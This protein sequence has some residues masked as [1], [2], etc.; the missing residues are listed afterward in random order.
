M[1]GAHNL[2]FTHWGLNYVE[3]DMGWNYI[4]GNTE[5]YWLES[6]HLG[7]YW[8]QAAVFRDVQSFKEVNSLLP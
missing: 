8:P 4:G 6:R 1:Q 3:C 5:T 2:S 7:K